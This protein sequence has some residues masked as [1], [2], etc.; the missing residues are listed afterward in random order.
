MRQLVPSGGASKV[1]CRGRCSQQKVLGEDGRRG[2]S[3]KCCEEGRGAGRSLRP[4]LWLWQAAGRRNCGFLPGLAAADSPYHWFPKKWVT[5]SPSMAQGRW[6]LRE[7]LPSMHVM[8]A[9]LSPQTKHCWKEQNNRVS[10]RLR[11]S[12]AGPTPLG[13]ASWVPFYKDA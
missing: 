5:H 4:C 9:P 7:Q 3:E 8:V 11:A 1:S 12:V 6:K 13:T 2:H 10:N